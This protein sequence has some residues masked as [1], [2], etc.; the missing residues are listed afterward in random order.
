MGWL[1]AAMPGTPTVLLLALPPAAGVDVAPTNE[2]FAELAER[3]GATYVDCTQGLEAGDLRFYSDGGR[4]QGGSAC[5]RQLHSQ[6]G[7]S[8]PRCGAPV[9][10]RQGQPPARPAAPAGTHLNWQG[11][12]QLL[13]CVLQA[14]RGAG[15]DSRRKLAG[16]RRSEL[17]RRLR[18]LQ[19]LC[20][21]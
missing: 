11:Q 16:F 18:L 9:W 6:L 12:E 17:P 13:G 1:Q 5:R 4:L 14:A 2:R 20:K 3:R 15:R 7:I 8:S 21:C 10:H 19:E